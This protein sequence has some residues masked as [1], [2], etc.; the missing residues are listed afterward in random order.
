MKHYTKHYASL[1]NLWLRATW[2]GIEQLDPEQREKLGT[3]INYI[4]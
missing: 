4:S 2:T 1:N 3:N